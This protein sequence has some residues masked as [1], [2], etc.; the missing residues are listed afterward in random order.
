MGEN[1]DYENLDELFRRGQ[2]ARTLP[3]ME[4][5]ILRWREG[6]DTPLHSMTIN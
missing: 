4:G 2:G 6:A 5:L 3:C 1:L